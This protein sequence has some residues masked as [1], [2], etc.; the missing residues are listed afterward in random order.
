MTTL[1][2]TNI[3]IAL[4]DPRD[5]HHVNV[6]AKANELKAL[7]PLIVSDMVY[8]ESSVTLSR[9]EDMDEAIARLG[10]DRV[11]PSDNA[12]FI[13]GKV[14]DK[15]RKINKGPKLGVLPDFVIGA[16]AEAMGLPLF[17][18]NPKDFVGYFPTVT[19][20]MPDQIAPIAAA[21]VVTEP[22]APTT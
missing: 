7:G 11:S 8:C 21:V 10:F 13:A 16:T 6:L 4:M 19:I 9:Q 3:V 14:F 18:T 12:L 2:D 22:A 20:I 1:V 5:P 15:Y 17:T